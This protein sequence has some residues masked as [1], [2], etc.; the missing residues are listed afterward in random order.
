MN[1]IFSF[2]AGIFITLNLISLLLVASWS[3]GVTREYW[4]ILDQWVFTTTNPWLNQFNAVWSWFWAILSIR[5]ADLIPLFIML[6]FFAIKGAIFADKDRLFGFVGFV[7]LLIV[8]LFVRETLDFYADSENLGRS[9]P[10]AVMDSVVRLSSIY[11]SFNLKDWDS[12]SFPGDH[13]AVLFTWLGYCLFF[14]RNKW[15]FLVLFFVV[16]F[17]LPR[18]MAGAHWLS[19]ILVGGVSTALTAL[20]FGLYTPI[21]NKA[22]RG[23]TKI[24]NNILG[25]LLGKNI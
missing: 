9:S 10:T 22:Q 2:R 19:D 5:V 11:P 18:L 3:G 12:D 8:M 20:A 4:D 1:N 23:L 13:A 6:W 17:S 7:L 25:R 16:L 21:L 24:A 15:S 14:V